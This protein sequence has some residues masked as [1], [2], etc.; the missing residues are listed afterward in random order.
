MKR[1]SYAWLIAAAIALALAPASAFANSSNPP[2]PPFT[3][4]TTGTHGGSNND[5]EVGTSGCNTEKTAKKNPA[6]KNETETCTSP[7]PNVCPR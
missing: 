3:E 6:G 5:C 2:S 4:T 1:L 7:N